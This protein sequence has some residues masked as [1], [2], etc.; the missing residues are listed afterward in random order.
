MEQTGS[1]T[2]GKV[3]S[4]LLRFFFPMLFTNLLQQIYTFVDTV[5]VGKG[6]GDNALAAVGNMST[7][8]L[9]IIGFLQGIANGFS[10]IIAQYCGSENHTKLRRS[11]AVSIK[12]SGFLSLLLTV[13]SIIVLR[14][15]L[16]VMQ[17]SEQILQDSLQYGSII[18]GGLIITMAYNLF[19]CIL[20]AFGDSKTPLLAIIISSALNIVLDYLFIF[21]FKTGVEGAAIATVFSQVVSTLICILQMRKM[22]SLCLT[23]D[24]F[25]GGL[26][27][28]L[29]LLKNGIPMACMNSVTAAG[30]IIVQ[31]YVN[32]LGVVY[33]SAYA[34]CNKYINLFMLPSITAG[35][36]ISAF[37]SQNYGAKK[38]DR[39]RKGVRVSLLIGFFSYV[40]CGAA[41]MCLPEAL[42]RIMLN[43]QQS[44]ALASGFLR[45]CGSMFFSLNFLFIFRSVVQGMGKPLIP[46]CSG[47]LEMV[48]RILIIVLF[49]SRIGFQAAAYAEIAAWMGALIL[50]LVAYK[51]LM[52]RKIRQIYQIDG[53]K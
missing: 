13:F 4:V 51:V 8:T 48:L 20:R 21:V 52:Q 34:V 46:M 24:D 25:K 22:G 11:I 16:L 35:F 6:L 5:I 53:A 43:G 36:S 27:L 19:S 39:I 17:T 37:T 7:V 47:I 31:S 9:F 15:V 32:A 45:I 14:S 10:V 2:S 12:L 33:T 30:C 38:F 49:L 42:A 18:V 40:L 26:P 44:I 3:S 29:E 50:N 28:S 41:M 23:P 1:L